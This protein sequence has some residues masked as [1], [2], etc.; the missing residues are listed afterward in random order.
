MPRSAAAIFELVQQMLETVAHEGVTPVF[1]FDDT[2]RWLGTAFDDPDRLVSAFFGNVMLQLRDL[3]CSLVVAVHPRY[4]QLTGASESIDRVLT[5]RI[6]LPALPDADAV[7]RLLGRRIEAHIDVDREPGRWMGASVHD[8]FSSD[9][10]ERPFEH[11]RRG[12][13]NEL[14]TVVRTVH[15]ALAEACDVRTDLITDEL[16]D[17]SVASWSDAR[18]GR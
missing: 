6:S 12:Q 1:L 4:R 3:P 9:A 8:V 5:T 14:R 16:I 2:D 17:S 15:V 18:G 11:Y 7:V 10:V 13:G